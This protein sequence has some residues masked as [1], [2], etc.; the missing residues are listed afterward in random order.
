MEDLID[1]Y[2]AESNRY[3]P[4]LHRPT[5]QKSFDE[6]LHKYDGEFGAVVLLVC[7]VGSRFSNDPRVFVEEANCHRSYGWKWF[8]QVRIM[9]T[10]LLVP[11][12]LYDVQFCCVSDTL[13]INFHR[14][15][16]ILQLSVLFL[17]GSYATHSAWS[18]IGIGIRFAQEVGAHRRRPDGHTHTVEDELWKRAFW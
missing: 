7:A 2:F 15:I 14:D 8:S 3:L 4:L 17:N 12:S 16:H 1:L 11:P 10:N 9:R 5:F 18:I 6:G 13:P